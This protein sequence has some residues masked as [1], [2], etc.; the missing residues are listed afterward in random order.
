MTSPGRAHFRREQNV[1]AVK[2]IE[3]E[4]RFLT[5]QLLRPDFLGEIQF[6]QSF[7][8]MTRAAILASGWPMAFDCERHGARGVRVHFE[9]VNSFRLSTAY[10]TFIRRRLSN[11]CAIACV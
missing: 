1:L 7:P 11:S 2:F 6:L 4:H 5:A 10:C 9:D 3:R 8:T